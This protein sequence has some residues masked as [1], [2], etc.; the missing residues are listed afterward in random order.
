MK[1]GEDKLLVLESILRVS[2]LPQNVF[3][4]WRGVV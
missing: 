4:N 2:L 3:M 1:Q